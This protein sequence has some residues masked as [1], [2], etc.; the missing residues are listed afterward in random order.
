M[1]DIAKETGREAKETT[2]RAAV[3]QPAVDIWEN[4]TELVIV[5]DVPGVPRDRLDLLVEDGELRIEAKR[6]G[7]LENTELHYRRSFALPEG[8][9][10]EEIDAEVKDGVLFVHL[11]KPAAKRPRRIEVRGPVN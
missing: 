8:I 5:A 4:D 3:V 11:P 6:P 9:D 2:T 7:H 1:K 10:G